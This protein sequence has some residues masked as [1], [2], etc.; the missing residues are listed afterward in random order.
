[1]RF[2]HLTFD[3]SL[4]RERSHRIDDDDID[5]AGAHQHVGDFQRLLAGIGLRNQKF[6]NVHAE[7]RGVLRIERVLGIDEGSCTADF[8]HLRDDRQGQRGLAR[9]FRAIDFHHAA[10]RQTAHAQSHIQAQ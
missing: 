8:L 2:T 7:F 6:I 10:A 5:R 1:M 3:L 4:G 9:G